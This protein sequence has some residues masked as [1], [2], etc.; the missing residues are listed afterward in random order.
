MLESS[1]GNELNLTP[2]TTNALSADGGMDDVQSRIEAKL[3]GKA[4]EAVDTEEKLEAEETEDQDTEE[5]ESHDSTDDSEDVDGEDNSDEDESEGEDSEEEDSDED[6]DEEEAVEVDL[7]ELAEVLKLDKTSVQIDDEGE[8]LIKTK[9]DDEEAFVPLEKLI[10]SYQLEKHLRNKSQ[11]DA[12]ARKAFQQEKEQK[13]TELGT[14]I[15]DTMALVGYL[16]KQLMGQADPARLEQLRASDPGQYSATILELQKKHQ[17]IEQVKTKAQE[18]VMQKAHEDEAAQAEAFQSYIKEETEKAI[19]AVPEWSTP[20]VFVKDN[21]IMKTFAVEELGFSEQEYDAVNDHRLLKLFRLAAKGSVAPKVKE[22]RKALNKKKV[23]RI[24]KSS[25]K[26]LSR[27]V[28][29]KKEEQKDRE[30][31][32][33]SGG[34]LDSI[35]KLI[36]KRL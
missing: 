10:G 9:V 6:E 13:E 27:K 28:R 17:E 25:N 20:G 32:R 16:E 14:K 21:E 18:F 24:L 23:P 15:L 35:A 19:L 8:V 31:V 12:E 7:E 34:S 1:S 22:V 11:K 2:D 36:E 4:E 3:S 33:E 29:K 26:D 5:V 30:Y